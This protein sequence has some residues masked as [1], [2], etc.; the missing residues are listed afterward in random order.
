MPVLLLPGVPFDRVLSVAIALVQ[1]AFKG[2]GVVWIRN[3]WVAH[4][5]WDNSVSRIILTL[6]KCASDDCGCW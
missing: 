1:E 4:S 5:R 6:R 2:E 3:S